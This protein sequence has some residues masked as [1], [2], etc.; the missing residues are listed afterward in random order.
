MSLQY[1]VPDGTLGSEVIFRCY[2]SDGV[3]AQGQL[4]FSGDPSSNTPVEA[5]PTGQYVISAQFDDGVNGGFSITP[6][7]GFYWSPSVCTFEATVV[8][9][10]GASASDTFSRAVDTS[11]IPAAPVITTI[12]PAQSGALATLTTPIVFTTTTVATNNSSTTVLIEFANGVFETAYTTA[13]GFSPN[14]SASSTKTDTSATV[15]TFSAVRTSWIPGAVNV[16]VQSQ[17]AVYNLQASSTE[18]W[19]VTAPGTFIVV[20]P[21]RIRQNGADVRVG[22]AGTVFQYSLRTFDND[23]PSG[24]DKTVRVRYSVNGAAYA[25]TV[26]QKDAS[27]ASNGIVYFQLPDATF[28]SAGNVRVELALVDLSGDTV[29]YPVDDTIYIFVSATLS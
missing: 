5:C 24:T 8:S 3:D 7:S 10:L 19:F 26:G 29:T 27:Y 11:L 20:D 2:G 9:S 13:D 12:S 21:L 25:T 15:D 16:T 18:T 14:Y 4:M 6:G 22:D 17:R 23:I 1:T 28:A